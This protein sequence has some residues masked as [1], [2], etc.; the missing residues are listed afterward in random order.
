MEPG[1]VD[2]EAVKPEPESL[3]LCPTRADGKVPLF[4]HT[5]DEDVC[6]GR[7]RQNYHKCHDCKHA[8]LKVKTLI[9]A[10]PPL[11]R[12]NGVPAAT[13]L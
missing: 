11:R 4:A 3:R 9:P 5:I 8:G 12:P 13:D 7:Q 1:S 2:Q 6:G 10:P